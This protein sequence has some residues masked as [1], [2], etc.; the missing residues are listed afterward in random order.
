MT[1]TI[2]INPHAATEKQ[3]ALIKKLVVER[4]VSDTAAATI[5]SVLTKTEASGIIAMMLAM[6]KRPKVTSPSSTPTAFTKMQEFLADVPKGKYAVP[7][8]ELAGT[9]FTTDNDLV[10]VEV[11]EYKGTRFVS[12]L[13]GSWGGFTR[14]KLQYAKVYD[15]IGIVKSDPLKY[16]QAFGQHYTCCGSCGAE[17]TDQRSRE[18][19]LGPE[20]RKKFGL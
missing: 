3:W 6:P 9:S 11:R 5:P 15:V 4:E 10:F 8:L 1:T 19:F 13:L 20:C 14:V 18:L 7:Q 16:A 12:Q 2:N 17:L